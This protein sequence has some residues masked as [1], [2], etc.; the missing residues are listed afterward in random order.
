[1]CT[2]RY[3]KVALRMARSKAGPVVTDNGNFIL[4]AHFGALLG[5]INPV[6]NRACSQLYVAFSLGESV[7]QFTPAHLRSR[8]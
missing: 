4:D 8:K 6:R 5:E 7:N 1:M 2:V 3:A